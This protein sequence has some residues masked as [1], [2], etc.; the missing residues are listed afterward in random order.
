MR[1][2]PESLLDESS[3]ESSEASDD[4]STGDVATTNT[5]AVFTRRSYTSGM[6][7]PQALID[8]S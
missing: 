8:E 1:S 5:V 7:R 4:E 6:E 3:E 2:S